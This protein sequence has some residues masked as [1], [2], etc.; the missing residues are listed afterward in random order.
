MENKLE[1][2]TV[3][4]NLI[5]LD[6]DAEWRLLNIED[7]SNLDRKIGEVE[8]F[9]ENNSGIGL[10]EFEKDELYGKAQDIYV[11]FKNTLRDTKFNLHLNR[12]CY[13]LLTDL[14]LKKIEYDVNTVFIAI[15]L[16]G[17]MSKMSGSQY[18]NDNEYKSFQVDPTQLTYVYHLI[19]GHKVKGLTKEAYTF[20][21]LL[22]RISE[23]SKIINYYDSFAKNLPEE[24][25]KWALRMDTPVVGETLS[26]VNENVESETTES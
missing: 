10:S 16:T 23:L 19:S 5:L 21:N 20:S 7:E 11:E 12:P 3:K 26:P 2:L 17:L 24:I 18:K 14:V 15:E 4:P 1:V 13:N 25:Q 8:D 22:I 9:I 6:G